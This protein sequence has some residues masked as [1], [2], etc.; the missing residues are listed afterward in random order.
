MAF[1]MKG[2]FLYGSPM[3]KND[4]DKKKKKKKKHP[5]SDHFPILKN[6]DKPKKNLD[7]D[8]DMLNKSF[9][10]YRSN[11]PKIKKSLRKVN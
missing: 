10:I 2:S 3:K 7:I 5:A 1:K 9:P 8:I 11:K 4:D 6:T